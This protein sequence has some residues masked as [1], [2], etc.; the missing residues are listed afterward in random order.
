MVSMPQQDAGYPVQMPHMGGNVLQSLGAPQQDTSGAEVLIAE[1]GDGQMSQ[2][3]AVDEEAVCA[4]GMPQGDCSPA[5][6]M[7]CHAGIYMV[8][9]PEG[10]T[11]VS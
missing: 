5:A 7:M 4:W 2:A 8:P 3:K 11:F 10:A 1:L 9:V 6:Q